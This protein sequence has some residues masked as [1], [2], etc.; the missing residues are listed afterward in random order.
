M[1]KVAIVTGATGIVGSAIL[2]HLLK[3]PQNDWAKIIAISRRSPEVAKDPR[4]VHLSLDL[5]QDEADIAKK[6]R[7]L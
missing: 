3:T 5:E 1:G 7:S 4:Y 6:V 2:E